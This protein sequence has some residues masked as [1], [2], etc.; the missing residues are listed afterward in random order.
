MKL[1]NVAVVVANAADAT[2]TVVLFLEIFANISTIIIVN[3]VF[4]I[5]SID[6]E[7][8]VIEIFSLPLKYPLSTDDIATINTEGASAIIVN[9]ASGIPKYVLD[10]LFAVKNSIVEPKKPITP[11]IEIAILKILYA[12]LLSPIADFEDINP[13]YGVWYSY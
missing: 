13:C 7:F 5:C 10:I 8:A 9:S 3:I 6:C 4:K 12:P 1:I 2:M 11:N